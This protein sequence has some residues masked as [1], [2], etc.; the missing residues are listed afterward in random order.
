MTSLPA[1]ITYSYA[2]LAEE[3][4]LLLPAVSLFHGVADEDVLGVF[5]AAEGVPE[6]FAGVGKPQWTAVLEDAVRVGL[7]TSIG[8]GMYQIHPALPGYLAAGWQAEDPAGYGQ[9]RAAG[10]QALCAACGAFGMW[11]RGQ[12]ASGDAAFAYRIIGFHRRT[13]GAM[14][15]WAL[16]H[17]AWDHADGILR[18][19]NRYWVTRGLGEEANAWTDRILAAST[20]P[21]QDRPAAGSPAGS[22]WLFTITEQATRQKQAGQLGRA[23]DTYRRALTYLQDLPETGWTRGNIAV[24]YHQLGMIA[25]D[26][27]RL[28]EAED[29]CRESLAI[30]EDL[31]D[32]S[33]MASTYNELGNI[34]RNRGQPDEAESWYR[35]A[36]TI[37]EELSDEP[38]LSLT[39]HGL[40]NVAQDRGQLEEAKA[41]YRKSLAVKENL[42]DRPGLAIIYHQL[43]T[44][45]QRRRQLEEAEDWYRKSLAVKEELSDRPGVAITYH[46]LGMTAQ[47]RGRLEEAEDWYR[48]SLAVKEDLGDRPHLAMTYGQ[49]GLLEEDRQRPG[50]ALDWTVKCVS[51]FDQFPH[52]LTGPGPGHLARLTGQLGMQALEEAWRRVT[53]QA[54]PQVVR[55]YVASHRDK[56]AEKGYD[57]PR[58]RRGPFRR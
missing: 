48:K 56:G 44:V 46:Q 25:E 5:S 29:W 50:Q 7:L 4:R 38:G 41:W 9:E 32:R 11:L 53:G 35:K 3:T 39:Y 31:G 49:L 16:D 34:A 47:D 13:L 33:G 40:G 18:A 17:H 30:K 14:L 27:G 57:R 51:L 55:D 15:S 45:A 23:G 52:P 19:L 43:G 6:R 58:R 8:A 36:L 21:G 37:K 28:S 42:G 10:E 26:S 2:H 12:I 1:C 20:Q 54:L 24:L 22:L